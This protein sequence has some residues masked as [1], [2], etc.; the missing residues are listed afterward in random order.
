MRTPRTPKAGRRLADALSS[1]TVK[2]SPPDPA[3]AAAVA[4]A[5]AERAERQAVQAVER[6]AEIMR[7]E[8]GGRSLVHSPSASS[9]TTRAALDDA[10]RT[11]LRLWTSYEAARVALDDAH[12][13]LLTAMHA[14]NNAELAADAADRMLR[15]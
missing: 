10:R 3:V 8:H 5:A 13:K 12:T 9:R 15:L 11:E 1:S 6:E 2:H 14:T 7:V 4:A